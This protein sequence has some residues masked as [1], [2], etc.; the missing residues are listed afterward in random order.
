[1]HQLQVGRHPRGRIQPELD[2]RPRP[3]RPAPRR[4]AAPPRKL[5]HCR[6]PCFRQVGEQPPQVAPG[7]G[8]HSP[9]NPVIELGLVQAAGGEVLGQPTGDRLAL[10]VGD[11]QVLVGIHA[12]RARSTSPVAPRVVAFI[13]DHKTC[14]QSIIRLVNPAAY[15]RSAARASRTHRTGTPSRTDGD[16][17]D[18]LRGQPIAANPGC[19]GSRQALLRTGAATRGTRQPSRN[20]LGQPSPDST[21]SARTALAIVLPAANVSPFRG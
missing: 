17:H 18:G 7:L 14:I 13:Y 2:R 6:S 11:A 16:A 19:L 20:C 4:A 10:G 9:P 5:W 12:A 1:M 3:A 8:A 21:T 15:G